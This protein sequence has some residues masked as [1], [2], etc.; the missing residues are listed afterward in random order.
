M[1][2]CFQAASETGEDLWCFFLEGD[3]RPLLPEIR[4][5]IVNYLEG[6]CLE[7]EGCKLLYHPVAVFSLFNTKFC[8]QCNK[9]KFQ[10]ADN[11]GLFNLEP[12]TEN[13]KRYK[14]GG[15]GPPE[16]LNPIK[17]GCRNDRG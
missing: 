13:R 2:S 17:P 5:E 3:V 8:F 9:L 14:K 11:P 12:I 1:T 4:G 16:Q 10:L 7:E 6:L 15:H